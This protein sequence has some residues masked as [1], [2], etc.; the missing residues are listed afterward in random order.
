MRARLSVLLLSTLAPLAPGDYAL[1]V[2]A[3]DARQVT[4]FR[5]IP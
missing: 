5:M 1:E 3:G 4:W 2:S